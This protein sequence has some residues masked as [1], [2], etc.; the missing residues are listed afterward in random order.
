MQTIAPPLT[1]LHAPLG[2]SASLVGNSRSCRALLTGRVRSARSSEISDDRRIHNAQD[3]DRD[4]LVQDAVASVVVR[5]Y[6][7]AGTTVKQIGNESENGIRTLKQ[8]KSEPEKEL[9]TEVG[10]K[11]DP[12]GKPHAAVALRT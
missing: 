2:R 4:S 3:G 5:T 9:G 11:S 6:A 1:S 12:C 7:R 10:I 8:P